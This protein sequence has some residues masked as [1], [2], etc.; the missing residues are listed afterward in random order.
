[1]LDTFPKTVSNVI[2]WIFKL[3]RILSNHRIVKH[4]TDKFEP[5]LAASER[6]LGLD[7]N[8]TELN[9]AGPVDKISDRKTERVYKAADFIRSEFFV[10]HIYNLL[11]NQFDE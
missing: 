11:I 1:M 9:V 2:A 3:V 8:R 7:V 5:H 6:L 4:G 10:F